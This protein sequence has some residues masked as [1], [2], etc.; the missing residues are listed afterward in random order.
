MKKKHCLHRNELEQDKDYQNRICGYNCQAQSSFD[1][2]AIDNANMNLANSEMKTIVSNPLERSKSILLC[3]SNKHTN[4]ISYVS[5]KKIINSLDNGQDQTIVFIKS[6]VKKYVAESYD[7]NST[8]KTNPRSLL[9]A[10]QSQLLLAKGNSCEEKFEKRFS[11]SREAIQAKLFHNYI[12]STKIMHAPIRQNRL[13]RKQKIKPVQRHDEEIIVQE[14]FISSLVSQE[15]CVK[16]QKILTE[17][18]QLSD[19]EEDLRQ[20]N[21]NNSTINDSLLKL[22]VSDLKNDL[23]YH[24]SSESAKYK[25]SK[26]VTDITPRQMCT[27]RRMLSSKRKM[28]HHSYTLNSEQTANHYSNKLKYKKYFYKRSNYKNERTRNLQSNLC[29]NCIPNISCKLC[30]KKVVSDQHLNKHRKFHIKQQMCRLTVITPIF[31]NETSCMPNK[32]NYLKKWKCIFCPSV[33][34]SAKML[35][36]HEETHKYF[37]CFSCSKS[38]LSNVLL[39]SHMTSQCVKNIRLKSDSQ[40]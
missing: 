37:K 31:H 19:S 33:F 32:L 13:P 22:N 34:F 40:S 6:P 16:E 10:S 21:N 9:K 25:R 35:N 4:S 18:I 36:V 2:F 15:T 27:T 24:D 5:I 11:K 17:C 23:I 29:K 39:S 1:D 12:A 3:N 20:K 30:P 38:F 28:R 8:S 26:R 14:V 7:R